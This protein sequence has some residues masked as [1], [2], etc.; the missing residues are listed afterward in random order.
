MS[1]SCSTPCSCRTRTYTATENRCDTPFPA[2]NWDTPVRYTGEADVRDFASWTQAI[3][4][5][6]VRFEF[7][8]TD[9]VTAA[10]DTEVLVAA[11]Q[12]SAYSTG[13]SPVTVAQHKV[14]AEANDTGTLFQASCG[15]LIPAGKY[16]KV[17]GTL[18]C[19]EAELIAESD[20][21]YAESAVIICEKKKED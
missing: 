8:F 16:Y 12:M 19:T 17:L 13:D 5:T 9:N 11:I 14:V 2:A 10:S 15:F 18:P 6:Y 7:L 4:D 20:T 3:Y 1:C 21:L